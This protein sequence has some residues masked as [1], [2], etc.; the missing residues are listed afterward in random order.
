MSEKTEKPTQKRLQKARKEGQFAV[1]KGATSAIQFVAFLLVLGSWGRG[2]FDEVQALTREVFDRAFRPELTTSSLTE[3]CAMLFRHLFVPLMA[4]GMLVFFAPITLH[5]VA[6]R[7]GFSLKPMAPSGAKLNP[8]SKLMRMPKQNAAAV[9]QASAVLA[10]LAVA[11]YWRAESKAQELFAMPL[12]SFDR[13][14]ETVFRSFSDLLWDAA[15]VFVLAGAVD[16]IWQRFKFAKQMKMSRQDIQDEYRETEG[17]PQ[18]KGRLKRI[19]R[20]HLRRRM[21]R[22]VPEATAVVVNPTH[23]AVALLYD[24]ERGSAPVVVA[25]GR[26]YLAQRIRTLAETHRVPVIEN[27]P[28]ARALYKFVPLGAEIPDNLY[29]AVAEV[30]A[31]IYKR[32][33]IRG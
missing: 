3:V 9:L 8:F 2:W 27:P 11:A 7:F 24:S 17:N 1:S 5:L 22:R 13:I 33:G 25:K 31:Y 16:F 15:G 10:L 20:D 32:V 30:L 29:R 12:T 14:R 4:G 18:T 26:N 19:R 28:L 21:M 6:T 23:Y